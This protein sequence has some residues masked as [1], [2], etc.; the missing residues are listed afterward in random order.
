MSAWLL[1]LA[2]ESAVVS[3]ADGALAILYGQPGK[4]LFYRRVKGAA[5]GAPVDW[6][7]AAEVAVPLPAG[8][9]DLQA[10]Y[11]ESSVYQDEAVG[12]IHAVVVGAERQFEALF[13]SVVP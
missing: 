4:G 9:G 2:L 1:A 12:G 10:I 8:Y 6:A 11:P 5:A 3:A 13:V 7:V